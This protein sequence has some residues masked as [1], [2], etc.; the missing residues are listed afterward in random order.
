M[1]YLKYLLNAPWTFLGIIH[2]LLCLPYKVEVRE[3]ALI[4]YSIT[5]GLIHLYKPKVRGFVV[6]NIVTIRRNV[7]HNILEHELVHIDQCMRYPFIFYFLYVYELLRK[8]YWKNRFEVEAYTKTDTW[9]AE[10]L[11]LSILQN[12]KYPKWPEMRGARGK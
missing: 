11:P 7:P 6:G 3:H 1:N 12:T 2:L 5:C 8:G 9:P 4:F 10:Q